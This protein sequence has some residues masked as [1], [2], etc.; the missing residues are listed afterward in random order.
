MRHEDSLQKRRCIGMK[1]TLFDQNPA[2]CEAWQQA[3]DGCVDVSIACCDV[4]DLPR[5]DAIVT[6]GNS[7]GV[8]TGGIDLA[9]RNLFGFNLQDV[10]QDVILRNAEPLPVGQAIHV[11]VEDGPHG[12]VI[13]APT[14]Y[15]P[16]LVPAMDMVYVMI[17][18][19]VMAIRHKCKSVAMTGFGTHTGG[20]PPVE[21]AKAMR[22]GYD[23]ALALMDDA[24]A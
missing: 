8:M 12:A 17:V 23:A 16:R 14:M 1:I 13:Y 7:F 10:I 5:H 21:A 18:A 11:T 24:P 19:M 20:V 6:S 4:A 9:V 22:I 15:T 2:L 3:F